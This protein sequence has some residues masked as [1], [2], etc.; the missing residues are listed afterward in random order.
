MATV[1]IS[2]YDSINEQK[3]KSLMAVCADVI[4]HQNPDRLYFLFSSTGGSVDA[5]IALFNYLR[6][7]PVAL[8]MHNTGS[9]DSIANVVYL[10]ADER[11]ANPNSSFLLHGIKWG[12][13]QGANLDWAALQ[14]TI[15]RF[16]A[17][18]ARMS[19]IISSRTTIRQDELTTLYREGNSVG[20]EFAVAKGL[21][22]AVREAKVPDGAPLV[23]C[24][25]A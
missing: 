20:L 7:L 18:E 6:A 14:E 3:A 21:T 25:F 13:A 12:F 1:Y 16:R 10:A 2:Y 24:N 15:S 8:T 4:A 17:D 23:S 9:V 11:F 19:G 5:G 22:Q